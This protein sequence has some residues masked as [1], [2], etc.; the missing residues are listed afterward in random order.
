MSAAA[1]FGAAVKRERTG[2][3][4]TQRQ[5]AVNCHVSPGVISAIEA[6]KGTSLNFAGMLA[7]VFGVPLA[8]MLE[9]AGSDGEEAGRD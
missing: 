3:G 2:H 1:D 6:G 4:W 9:P 8:S 7:A 5:L